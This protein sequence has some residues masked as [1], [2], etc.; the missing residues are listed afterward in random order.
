MHKLLGYNKSDEALRNRLDD[1]KASF[2]FI[3]ISLVNHPLVWKMTWSPHFKFS[4][5]RCQCEEDVMKFLYLFLEGKVR[6]D[7]S[8]ISRQQSVW[9][10]E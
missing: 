6:E 8:S 7:K 3:I 2:L 4:N 5:G 10:L 1:A 9:L